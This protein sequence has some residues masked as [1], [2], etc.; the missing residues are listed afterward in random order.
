MLVRPVFKIVLSWTSIET[1]ITV[2]R[3]AKPTLR[4]HKQLPDVR[5]AWEEHVGCHINSAS[6]CLDLRTTE[7]YESYDNMKHLCK[8]PMTMHRDLV[9]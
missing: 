5:N 3:R 4:F 2:I 1:F 8:C 6:S 9:Q 7:A